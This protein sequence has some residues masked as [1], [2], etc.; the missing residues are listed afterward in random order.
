MNYVLCRGLKNCPGAM[1]IRRRVFVEEQGFNDEF[2][3]I[4][5]NA[6]HV[7]IFVKERYAATGRLFKDKNGNAHIGRIAVLRDFR[8]RSLG[9][10]II[11]ILEKKALE[12]NL[13]NIELSAQIQA[14][15]FYIKLGYSPVGE[16]YLDENCPHIKMV[17]K[18][19]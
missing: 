7:V 12:L 8:N 5:K 16:E 9:S 4:D 2:D 10:F 14:M 3:D 11:A 19:T 18:L 13:N 1:D 15:D 17:K 6:Y